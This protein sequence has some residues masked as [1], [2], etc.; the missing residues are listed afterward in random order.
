MN[1]RKETFLQYCQTSSPH[2]DFI[3]Q[4]DQ[5][6]LNF[7]NILYSDHFGIRGGNRSEL[8][9]EQQI[10]AIVQECEKYFNHSTT[11]INLLG[12]AM[13]Q[14]KIY[15]C[16][17]FRKKLAIEMAEEYLKIGDSSKALTFVFPKFHGGILNRRN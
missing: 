17:R 14:F 15:K 9:N 16:P 10:I 12:Q 8:V 1:K 6:V 7:S 2:V 3:P 4:S 5:N 13:A 11:Y